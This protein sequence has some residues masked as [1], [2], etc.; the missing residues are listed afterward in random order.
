MASLDALNKLADAVPAMTQRAAKAAQANNAISMQQQLGS[1][2]MQPGINAN[3][4]AQQAAP[5]AVQQQTQT[6]L[7][8]GE[9]QQQ[10]LQQVGQMGL[11]AQKAQDQ[12][13][14]ASQQAAN[15]NELATR[16]AESR[17]TSSRAELAMRKRTTLA[18]QEAASRLQSMGITMDNK[19]QMATI[20]QREQ[21]TRLGADVKDEIL[22]SRLRFENDEM[23]RKFSNERQLADWTITNSKNEIELQDRMREM[24]QT[25]ER[26]IQLLEVAEQR[27]RQTL[28]ND[29]SQQ[30][31]TLDNEAKVKLAQM[32]ADMREKI[33]KK[34]AKAA[35]NAAMWQAG[36]T[37]VGAGV[38]A[39][40]GNP[41]AGAAVGGGIGTVA[42]SQ[43]G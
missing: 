10:Q 16:G 3:R 14:L 8:A 20:R 42:G 23:G 32:A 13:G 27:I 18:E 1:A 12:A 11:A 6:A 41:T 38:G 4:I 29:F 40:A 9:Q 25:A 31:Q 39:M 33:R 19:L 34:Q 7:A 15:Q 22:D 2:P 30:Q 36:G 17:L 43:M 26:E 28:V 21:L 35:N 37:I 24:Q 5:Q